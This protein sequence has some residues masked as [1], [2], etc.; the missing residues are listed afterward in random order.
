MRNHRW[1]RL[2]NQ[3]LTW[4]G[5]FA[6][7][8]RCAEGLLLL[9]RYRTDLARDNAALRMI[10]A[11]FGHLPRALHLAGSFLDWKGIAPTEEVVQEV[12]AL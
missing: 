10:T 4:S 9:H 8:L 11:E 6:M 3:P 5:W 12:N 7:L 1:R 2:L